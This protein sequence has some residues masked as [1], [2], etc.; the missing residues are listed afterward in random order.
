M[1][2]Q[3]K[4]SQGIPIGNDISYLLAEVVLAQIDR[5]LRLPPDRAYR[6]FDDYEISC[7]TREEA[8]RVKAKLETELRSYKLRL[9]PTKTN[10][11]DLPRPV[12]DE[13]KEPILERSKARMTTAEDMVRYFDVAFTQRRRFPVYPV[14]LYAIAVLFRLRR[15]IGDAGKVAQSSITQA[16]LAEP[17]CAQKAFALLSFWSLNGFELDRALLSSTVARMIAIHKAR[18]ATSDIAWALSFC[19]EHELPIDKRSARLLSL[20]DEAII[21]LLALQL[22]KMGLITD[23]F[24]FGRVSKVAVNADLDGPDWLVAYEGVRHG[25]IPAAEQRVVGNDFFGDL[26]GRRVTFFRPRIPKYASVIQP[27]GA[28]RWVVK[29]WMEALRGAPVPAE[30]VDQPEKLLDAMESD[31][32]RTEGISDNDVQAVLDL[33]DIFEP[34]AFASLVDQ[35]EPYALDFESEARDGS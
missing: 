27:G 13:W 35:D 8:E 14:L 22:R 33:L 11:T 29:S 20:T 34:D 4:V 16:L 15:P 3:G 26:L 9:N 32:R 31:F 19:V 5:S 28:P 1:D 7:E 2:S 10:I 6:W 12:E 17:G 25:F 30:E 23:G 21:V 18:G 24:N